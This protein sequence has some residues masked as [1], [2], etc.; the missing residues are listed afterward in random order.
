MNRAHANGGRRL[1]LRV[2]GI[3]GRRPLWPRLLPPS[4]LPRRGVVV[5]LVLALVLATAL[6][7]GVSAQQDPVRVVTYS[8]VPIPWPCPAP[9]TITSVASIPAAL[10][11]SES[12]WLCLY[13]TS[14]SLSPW[15][16][17]NGGS[18][19]ET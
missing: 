18:S 12:I 19:F 6:W 3:A 16:I 1:P 13:G 9:G 4:E 11:A 2:P 8:A 14:G 10:S 15:T 7:A 5:R 17:K